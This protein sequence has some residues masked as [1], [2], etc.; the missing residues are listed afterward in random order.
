MKFKAEG[1]VDSKVHLTISAKGHGSDEVFLMAN[2]ECIMGFY[3]GKYRLY[4]GG[5]K[6]EGLSLS[7][8]GLIQC[9][10]PKMVT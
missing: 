4:S 9:H 6:V 8:Q 3:E 5:S 10:N 1:V 7:D 2:G